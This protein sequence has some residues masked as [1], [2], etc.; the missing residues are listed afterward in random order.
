MSESGSN[1]SENIDDLRLTAKEAAEYIDESPGVIR[2]WL[3]E[4]KT[5]IPTI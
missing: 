4:L 1:Y 3:R 5:H 2:N